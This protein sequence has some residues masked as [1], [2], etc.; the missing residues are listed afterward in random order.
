MV[1]VIVAVPEQ[2]A[3]VCPGQTTWDPLLSTPC[4]GVD[5]YI[6]PPWSA[7]LIGL[8]NVIVAPARVLVPARVMS[9]CA[10]ACADAPLNGPRAQYCPEVPVAL[11][12]LAYVAAVI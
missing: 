4:V 8:T 10:P 2:S 12:P 6:W 9:P 5:V 1:D 11:P 3:G 7:P